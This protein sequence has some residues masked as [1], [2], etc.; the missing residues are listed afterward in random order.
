M[1]YETKSELHFRFTFFYWECISINNFTVSGQQ[2]C[3]D[4]IVDVAK[5][6]G[7]HSF[8]LRLLIQIYKW[9]KSA[10]SV[11]R[12]PSDKVPASLESDALEAF[13]CVKE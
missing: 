9:R 5:K 8:A 1:L 12:E 2:K 6:V 13:S 10:A 3:H 4:A 7:H 11:E